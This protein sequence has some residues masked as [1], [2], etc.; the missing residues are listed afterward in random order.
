MSNSW[1]ERRRITSV[2]TVQRTA[3]VH[4]YQLE[5][6]SLSGDPVEAPPAP[7][8]AFDPGWLERPEQ[9]D[10]S[11]VPHGMLRA[12]LRQTLAGEA[13]G[14]EP[15]I[16]AAADPQTPMPAAEPPPPAPQPPKARTSQPVSRGAVA[17]STMSREA[18]AAFDTGLQQ[19]ARPLA[20]PAVCADD[21]SHDEAP[22]LVWKGPVGDEGRLDGGA[23]SALACLSALP[24]EPQSPAVP[25]TVP[26]EVEAAFEAGLSEMRSC[27]PPRSRMQALQGPQ[28]RQEPQRQE[29]P[30]PAPR[31]E[32]LTP[33]QRPPGHE[34]EA[35]PVPARRPAEPPPL[36]LKDE[37]AA[38]FDA[39][40]RDMASLRPRPA[41][42]PPPGAAPLDGLAET[43]T[44][45]CEPDPGHPDDGLQPA[46]LALDARL[47]QLTFRGI[48]TGG[49]G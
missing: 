40:A 23:Q 1:D 20:S 30:A 10:A 25:M 49:A 28:R 47:A 38:A 42:P 26:Q 35:A 6:G 15:T 9:P 48:V 14:R 13:W 36:P 24:C 11:P 32:N 7:E 34:A 17:G 8:V 39:G 29:P 33:E 16:A 2:R 4:R 37:V 21:S 41:T 22:S 18:A 46:Q 44:D 12:S 27:L 43:E 5:A 31:N 45:R 3:A 19:V